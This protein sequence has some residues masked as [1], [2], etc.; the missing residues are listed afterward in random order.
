MIEEGTRVVLVDEMG[1]KHLAV[2]ERGMM[3]IRRLGAVDGTAICESS[4][5]DRILVAG[6]SFRI[7]RPSVGDIIATMDRRAQTIS[8]KDS[9][10]IPMYMDLACGSRVVEAGAGSGALTIVLLK[11][12]APAGAVYTYEIRDDHAKVAERNVKRSEHSPCWHLRMRDICQG[13]EEVGVDGVV[14]DIPNPWEALE[15]SA[16]A[17]RPGGHVCCY[18]PNANQLETTVKKMR[19]IGLRET[20]A[21]ETLQREMTVHERGVRPSFDMMGHTGYLAL[22]RKIGD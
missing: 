8:P 7:I 3:E 16:S 5:G 6:H 15:P 18:V 13:I 11:A 2:A 17:L 4:F 9:F 12:V 20:F 21:F 14:L 19:A 1:A 22:A 10:Q